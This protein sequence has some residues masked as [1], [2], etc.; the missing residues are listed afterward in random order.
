MRG[1]WR[2]AITDSGTPLLSKHTDQLLQLNGCSHWSTNVLVIPTFVKRFLSRAVD[3]PKCGCYLLEQLNFN[4]SIRSSSKLF[5]Y[6]IL[7]Y[8]SSD[9]PVLTEKKRHSENTLWAFC[10]VSRTENSLKNICWNGTKIIS[11]RNLSKAP[12]L[13]F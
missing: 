7:L 11:V 8:N 10:T 1:R 12:L 2:N 3:G 13:S 5:S 6:I 4:P 9:G